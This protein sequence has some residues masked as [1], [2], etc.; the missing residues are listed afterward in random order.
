[1]KHKTVAWLGLAGLVFAGA[2]SLSWAGINENLHSQIIN[3]AMPSVLQKPT[4]RSNWKSNPI[5]LNKL[6]AETKI[7]TYTFRLP[8]GYS[9]FPTPA[10]LMGHKPFSDGIASV[11]S[12]HVFSASY[13]AYINNFPRLPVDTKALTESWLSA[14]K[15]TVLQSYPDATFSREEYGQL[16]SLNFIRVYI[17]YHSN[18]RGKKFL[19][20]RFTYV[21]ISASG[22]IEASFYDNEPHSKVSLPIAEASILTLRKD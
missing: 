12:F 7:D 8:F 6:S 20:H 21:S 5:L 3:D 13:I 11:I 22:G 18:F 17:Q 2:A 4:V 9:S 1:M 16:S 10:G 15:A 19:V 14:Q